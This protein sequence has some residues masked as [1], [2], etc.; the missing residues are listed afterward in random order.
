MENS[1]GKSV[2]NAD[3]DSVTPSFFDR[4]PHE[5]DTIPGD[6]ETE[7]E[8]ERT[9][10][11][12]R[13]DVAEIISKNDLRTAGPIKMTESNLFGDIV[14]DPVSTPIALDTDEQIPE[15]QTGEDHKAVH[16][17]LPQGSARLP[18]QST[19]RLVMI[20]CF[21]AGAAVASAGFIAYLLLF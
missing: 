4:A 11:D 1:Q 6:W 8:T 2:G 17:G 12:Q 7:T 18:V 20:G 9:S 13:D 10:L 21:L 14:E 19:S 5:R 3:Q 15:R 16:A